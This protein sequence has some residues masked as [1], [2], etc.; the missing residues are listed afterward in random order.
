VWQ[1]AVWIVKGIKRRACS[2]LRIRLFWASVGSKE[3]VNFVIEFSKQ[4]IEWHNTFICIAKV[5]VDL[6]TVIAHCKGGCSCH[7]HCNKLWVLE[8]KTLSSWV[9]A[10]G[11]RVLSWLWA[12][13]TREG[14]V[15]SLAITAPAFC[16]LQ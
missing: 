5:A 1:I 11:Q 15:W 8:K 4:Q 12:S 10:Q 13:L 7:S 14:V 16:M 6:M 2:G 9:G 3:Q